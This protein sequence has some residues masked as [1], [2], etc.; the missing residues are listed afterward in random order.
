MGESFLSHRQSLR[1]KDRA[2]MGN[3]YC[4]VFFIV[5][6]YILFKEGV[7]MKKSY[8]LISNNPR[9]KKHYQEDFE[10]KFC[11]TLNEV[12][13][14][15]RDYIHAGHILISHPLA[16][17]VKPAQN[18]YRSIILANG[19]DLDYKSLEIIERAIFKVKQFQKDKQ[20][21]EYPSDILADYQVIDYTLISSGVK[22]LT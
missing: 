18:S 21:I 14:T 3:H 16:G 17:S 15:V 11:N 10:I 12:M 6:I 4:S 8:L 7:L 22:S 2:V 13:I 19:E 5:N 1:F 9:V 20:D